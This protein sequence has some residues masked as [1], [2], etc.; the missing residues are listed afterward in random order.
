MQYTIIEFDIILIIVYEFMKIRVNIIRVFSQRSIFLSALC[1]TG[2]KHIIKSS[3]IFLYNSINSILDTRPG[4]EEVRTWSLPPWVHHCI[5]G[6]KNTRRRHRGSGCYFFGFLFFYR[7]LCV[8][9][10]RRTI[11]SSVFYVDSNHI[12]RMYDFWILTLL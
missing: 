12:N 8:C 4:V 1:S 9:R 3:L 7:L 10:F 6:I 11:N 5:V 2:Y